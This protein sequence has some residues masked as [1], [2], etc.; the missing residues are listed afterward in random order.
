MPISRPRF[1]PTVE[2]LESRLP[3]AGDVS[4]LQIGSDLFLT[5]DEVNNRLWIVGNGPGNF[6]V[7]AIGTNLNGVNAATI[8]F[9][10][11][12]NIRLSM[13]N[14]NDT[15]SFLRSHLEGSLK[16]FGGDGNDVL[17]FGQGNHEDQTFGQVTAS[18][19][20]GE[21]TI[22]ATGENSLTVAQSF[23]VLGGDGN[24][25]INMET[26]TSVSLG[27]VVIIGGRDNDVATFSKGIVN[28][29]SIRFHGHSGYNSLQLLGDSTVRGNIIATGGGDQDIFSMGLY[30]NANSTVSGPMLLIHGE[31][32]NHVGF[33]GSTHLAGPLR[34]ESGS[35][36]AEFV[37]SNNFLAPQS[38]RFVAGDIELRLRDG[39]NFI[40][41]D[42]SQSDLQRLSVQTG[43]G[44][45]HIALFD[46]IVQGEMLLN[47]GDGN[48]HFVVVNSAFFAPVSWTSGNGAD[49]I[50]L[51]S[52]YV[53]DD[54][55][56]IFH[57]ALTIQ[58]G[59]GDDEMYV[60]A[61]PPDTVSFGG[62]V[63]YDGGD[64]DDLLLESAFDNYAIPPVII[65]FE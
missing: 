34:Y 1:R 33:H 21:D 38:N 5:G 22:G 44:D 24:N 46:A 3:L 28:T 4:A 48:N 8:N 14:G 62:E 49:S 58:L 17:F 6:A 60:A 52:G 61:S 7:Q 59:A 12:T 55:R 26:D 39:N 65:G 47:A 20:A 2:A 51:E 54:R 27:N 36:G 9:S 53:S 29:K 64:G 15:V 42:Q 40:R 50:A 37:S 16:F 25:A 35:G 57:A 30:A 10:G 23:I 45:D 19:G 41:F 11:V 43:T 32:S 13:G 56:T 63:L 18:L 31:G